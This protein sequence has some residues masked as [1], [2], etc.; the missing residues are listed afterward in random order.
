M[1]ELLNSI[2][3]YTHAEIIR[4]DYSQSIIICDLLVAVTNVDDESISYDKEYSRC[5]LIDDFAFDITSLTEEEL[6]GIE[7]IE[8]DLPS[9]KV[10]KKAEIK[11]AYDDAIKAGYYDSGLN[12]TIR[13]ADDDRNQFNQRITL[14]GLI[15]DTNKP[16]TTKIKGLD[17]EIYELTL[18]D[19]FNLMI[20]MGVYYDTE[21]W[22]KKSTLDKQI[23]N[24]QTIEAVNFISWS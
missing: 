15:P 8:T 1:I 2:D 11:N 3:G 19:F 9:A 4:I 16:A 7:I 24:A 10:S 23:D 5:I 13:I 6:A 17:N 20:N 22:T 14:L 21:I 18:Y 12:I